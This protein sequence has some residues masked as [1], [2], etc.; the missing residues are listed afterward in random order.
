MGHVRS[1][2]GASACSRNRMKGG[3]FT[4]TWQSDDEIVMHTD[5]AL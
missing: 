4:L 3:Y 5:R 1:V 2:D